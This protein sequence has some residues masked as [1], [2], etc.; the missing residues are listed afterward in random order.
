MH[1]DYEFDPGLL[2]FDVK[3]TIT[4]VL[5]PHSD[6]IAPPLASVE[7]KGQRQSRTRAYR[8]MPLK[9]D[10]LVIRPAMVA[11]APYAYGPHLAGWIVTAQSNLNGVP[12]HDPQRYTQRVGSIRL[13]G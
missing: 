13:F 10:D 5:R 8:I 11:L 2:L 12:H 6:Y 9:L 4:N 1:R 7:Q 3:G